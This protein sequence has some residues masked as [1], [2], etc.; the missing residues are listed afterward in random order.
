[1]KK[2]KLKKFFNFDFQ[3]LGYLQSQIK[4]K[5][6]VFRIKNIN[7]NFIFSFVY[8]VNKYFFNYLNNSNYY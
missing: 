3:S 5:I 1:M 8:F 4:L 7:F 6:F 2:I